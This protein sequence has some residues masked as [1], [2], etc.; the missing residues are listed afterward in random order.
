[1][2]E[3]GPLPE[4]WTITETFRWLENAAGFLC[5]T[6][7]LEASIEEAAFPAARPARGP[8]VTLRARHVSA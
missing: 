6:G 4:E 7:V 3:D 2:G 1:M 5:R 8:G